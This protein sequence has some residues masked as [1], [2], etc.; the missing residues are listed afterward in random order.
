LVAAVDEIYKNMSNGIAILSPACA[1][2]DQFSN[3][4]ERGEVYKKRIEELDLEM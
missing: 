4:Q 1:S 2:F 3:Y